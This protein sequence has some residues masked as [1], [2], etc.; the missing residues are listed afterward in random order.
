M[1][2][3]VYFAIYGSALLGALLLGDLFIHLYNKFK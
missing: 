1:E 2:Q 3:A